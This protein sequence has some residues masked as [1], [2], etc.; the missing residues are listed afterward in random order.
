MKKYA[1]VTIIGI[2]GALTFAGCGGGG[3]GGGGVQ[4]Q[5]TKLYLFGTMSSNSIVAGVTSSIVVPTF[6]DYS[7]FPTKTSKGIF[8]VRNG[9]I[10]ASGPNRAALFSGLFDNVSNTLNITLVNNPTSGFVN[11]S[12]STTRNNS[13]GNEIA[14]LTTTPGTTFPTTPTD[15]VVTK[16]R[17]LNITEYTGFKVNYA[18]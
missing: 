11:M 1:L 17:N 10:A 6:V 3:G 13:K 2:L 16:Y 9:V 18:P 5:V 7:A 15:A 8:L 4:K 14:T 12:G